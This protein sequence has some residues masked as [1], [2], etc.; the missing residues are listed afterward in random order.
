MRRLSV[1][2]SNSRQ[3]RRPSLPPHAQIIFGSVFNPAWLTAALQISCGSPTSASKPRENRATLDPSRE[4]QRTLR[5][6]GF[7]MG[8][9][10]GA[11]DLSP[12]GGRNSAQN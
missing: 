8:E 12:A 6:F 3:V 4:E 2:E 10:G 9:T 11:S 5:H 7:N 1:T